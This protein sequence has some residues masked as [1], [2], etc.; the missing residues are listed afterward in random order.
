MKNFRLFVFSV[1]LVMLFFLV[2]SLHPQ[3]SNSANLTTVKDTLQTSRLSIHARVDSTGTSTGGSNVKILTSAGADT[4][5]STANTITT[6]PFKAGDSLIIG[7]GSYTVLDILDSTNFTVTPVLLAGDTDNTDPI[8]MYV[9]PRHVVT[10]VTTSAVP[11]GFFQVLLPADGTTPNDG[12]ADDQGYDFN[13]LGNVTA[14]ATSSANYTFVTGVATASG[15][16]GCTSPANYHC[17]EAH[18]SGNGAIGQTITMFIGNINGVNTPI[19]PATDTAAAHEGT[20]ST[21]TVLVKNFAAAANPN[22]AT[23]LDS[24]N[25]KVA[26][27]E[28]VRV[29]ATVDPSITFTVAGTSSGAS[30]CGITTDTTTTVDSVP[31]GTLSLNTFKTG[32]QLLT[33]STNAVNGYS[34]TA[35]EN[36]AMSIDGLGVTTIADTVCNNPGTDCTST[37]EQNWDTASSAPGFGYSIAAVSGATAAFTSGANFS[38]RPFDTTIP[39]QIFS[40]TAVSNSHTGNV[41]YR[42]SVDATQAAGDYENQITYTATASF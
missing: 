7:T 35:I 10:F 19:A 33:V 1:V 24:A 30:A 37:S 17:F 29:S 15:A 23:P 27:I 2:S 22:S 39:R 36:A 28:A 9:K 8:Y 25:I 31:F 5:S 20:A 11:N 40:S 3:F 26:H 12:K 13:T 14:V 18:Y 32:A 38:S 34:V 42:V 41:C 21:Y 6:A 4:S 16:T